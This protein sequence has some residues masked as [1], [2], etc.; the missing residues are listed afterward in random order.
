MFPNLSIKQDRASQIYVEQI[1]LLYTNAYVGIAVSIVAVPLLVYLLWDAV[2]HNRAVAWLAAASTIAVVRFVAVR[3]YWH[4]SDVERSSRGWAAIF[5]TG[6]TMAGAGW[7]TASILL[8]PE[9]SLETQVF[10]GFVLGGMMLGGASLLAPRAEAFL[11][12]LLLTGIPGA[13]RLFFGPDKIHLGMGT[14]ALLFT[15]ATIVTTWRIHLTVRSALRLRF[16]KRD[17]VASLQLEKQ[18]TEALNQELEQRVE[19]RTAELHESNI[20]L[21]AEMEQRRQAEEELVRSRKLESLAVLAGGIAHDFNNFLTVVQGNATLAR[22]AMPERDTARQYL[23]QLLAASDRAGALASQLLSFSKG[24]DPVRRAVP[25]G[26]LLTEAAEGARAGTNFRLDVEIAE[27][28]WAAEVDASQ[29]SQAIHNVVV[30][31]C[32]SMP[33]GGVARL[34]A[35]NVWDDAGERNRYVRI[36]VEDRGCGIP[37]DVLP[38]IFDP[39]FTTKVDGRGLGLSAAYTIVNRH[40]GRITVDST[41]RSGTTVCIYLPACDLPV[42]DT[43]SAGPALPAKGWGRVLVMDDDEALR[44]LLVNALT[45]LGYEVESAGDGAEALALY[46]AGRFDAV[47]LDLTVPG[48]MGGAETAARLRDLDPKVKVI[49]SSGY[50]DAPVMADFRRYGFD[51]VIRKPWTLEQLAQVVQTVAE[52]SNA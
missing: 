41:P 7:G 37:A 15:L 39:Y 24:S 42:P 34:H 33:E 28:L 5:V 19:Q 25:M 2:P 11:P 23:D 1:R 21:Q 45:R 16:E 46:P 22:D 51:A 43:D 26:R 38:R 47:L 13:L 8:F 3:R 40:G 18:H 10:L 4:A 12:F 50:S 14:F 6:A 48:G 27:K 44:M 29:M 9:N 36:S 20:R 52:K 32:Q 30:N 17:L 49:V 35:E 31:A